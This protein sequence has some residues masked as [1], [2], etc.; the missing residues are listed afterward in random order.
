MW[1]GG[2]TR[3]AWHIRFYFYRQLSVW[4]FMPKPLVNVFSKLAMY[5]GLGPTP[6]DQEDLQ[7]WPNAFDFLSIVKYRFRIL[8][9]IWGSTPSRNWRY[10]KTWDQF[11]VIRRVYK[12]GLTH[13]LFFL[14]SNICFEF[15]ANFD[16]QC[17]LETG[18]VSRPGTNS[19]WLGGSPRV[20]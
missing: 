9:K 17:F 20:A 19:M 8:R 11:H 15:Y 6:H 12:G 18:D 10:L 7:G 1:L 5:Q 4:K 13:L 3:V 14:S 2:S 16:G